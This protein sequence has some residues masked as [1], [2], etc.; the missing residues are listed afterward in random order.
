M[1]GWKLVDKLVDRLG[2]KLGEH[3][4]DCNHRIFGRIYCCCIYWRLTVDWRPSGV[5][6][7]YCCR[8]KVER[9][10]L[11]CVDHGRL[12]ADY[13]CFGVLSST[14]GGRTTV[15]RLQDFGCPFIKSCSFDYCYYD[16]S[17]QLTTL[18]P[19]TLLNS[20]SLFVTSVA[21]K[22][23]VWAAISVSRAP[24][25]VPFFSNFSLILPYSTAAFVPNSTTSSGMRNWCRADWFWMGLELLL[26]PY[27]NSA[28]VIDEMPISPG[29]LDWN[30]LNTCS[31]FF[32]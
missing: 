28:S 2:D 3:E 6:L 1:V 15:V 4:C 32:W 17:I 7:G 30:L 5:G 27:C 12:T 16:C 25:G 22:L 19:F 21:S 20:F 9:W 23:F 10:I 24:I 8:L 18:S 11:C 29:S 14:V 13:C 31:G 26:I